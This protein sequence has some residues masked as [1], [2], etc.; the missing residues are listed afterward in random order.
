MSLIAKAL[1]G[2][3]WGAL[4]TGTTIIINLGYTAIMAR[5]LAPSAFGLIAMAQ[6]AIRFLSY[7]AQLGVGPAL[8]QKQTLS[9]ED[10]RAAL[11]LSVLV[12]GS[13]FAIMW[14]AA[15][16]AGVFFHTP[17]IVPILR[18]L[19]AAFLFSGISVVPIHLLRRK[20]RFKQLAI[21]ETTSYAFGYGVVGIGCALSGLGVWSLV[22]AVLGQEAVTLALAYAMTRHSLRPLLSTRHFAHF[23]R[24][25]S[26]YSVI[27]FME[28]IGGNLDSI[29]IGRWLGDTALGYYNRAQML[30]RLPVHHVANMLAKVIFPVLSSTQSD[31][32]KLAQAFLAG[33]FLIGC[34]A[35][36]IS[37]A[38]IPA[39]TDA[40]HTLLGERWTSIVPVV[41]IAALAVPFAF[42]TV[43]TGS[44]CDA[45]GILWPK[46]AIQSATLVV[47]VAAILALRAEGTSGF[48]KAM[49]IA[50]AF[51]LLLYVILHFRLLPIDL[52]AFV[53][54]NLAVAT[55]AG[56][57]SLAIWQTTLLLDGHA[58]PAPFRLIAEGLGGGLAFLTGLLLSW[59]W[60]RL[61]PAFQGIRDRLPWLRRLESL[62]WRKTAHEAAGG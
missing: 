42:L 30:V 53:L 50:E 41:Q 15:P 60:L 37:L 26:K 33:W 55:I 44:V 40:V 2:M 22:F 46:L 34:V 7:F 38:L 45:Q 56:G 16:L 24:F 20:L 31:K 58:W 48:A 57:T 32:P 1:S 54:V 28:Y 51:R 8:V 9:D 29:L 18:G 43:L 14:L 49:V 19:C 39:A 61:L 27:G 47:L 59:S 13:L 11:T 5:L 52:R 10:I 35:G 4:A 25:G 23:V 21:I 62:L 17:E 3:R 36:T 6:I 12:N